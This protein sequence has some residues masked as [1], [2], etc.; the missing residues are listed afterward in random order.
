MVFNKHREKEA[1]RGG[2]TEVCSKIPSRRVTRPNDELISQKSSR[3]STFRPQPHRQPLLFDA[4]ISLRKYPLTGKNSPPILSPLK[5]SSYQTWETKGGPVFFPSM[6]L[7][8]RL[9]EKLDF[10]AIN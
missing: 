7:C 4:Q 8:K 10:K 3:C 6:H 9:F 1:S 2:L 5:A